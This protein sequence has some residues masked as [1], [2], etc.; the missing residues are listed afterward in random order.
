MITG[1]LVAIVALSVP[2]YKDARYVL[3]A[4]PFAAAS[5]PAA[6]S[7]RLVQSCA[8]PAGRFADRYGYHLPARLAVLLTAA[9]GVCA[10]VGALHDLRSKPAEAQPSCRRREDGA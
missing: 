4:T 5:L 10:A 6:Q 8:L 2:A 7:R 1:G 9:G 3:A